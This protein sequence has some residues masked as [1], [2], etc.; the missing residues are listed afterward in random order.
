M[1]RFLHSFSVLSLIAFAS[2]LAQ[3]GD[4]YFICSEMRG[5]SG[6]DEVFLVNRT[7]ES[8]I[9]RASFASQAEPGVEF[10]LRFMP[11][12]L[13]L[14]VQIRDRE[15]D[16]N[17]FTFRSALKINRPVRLSDRISCSVRD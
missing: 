9:I 4:L 16:R 10:R 7:I 14:S 1:A 13:G 2:P 12:T 5:R 8:G 3:A 17:V 6:T 15:Q 11:Q